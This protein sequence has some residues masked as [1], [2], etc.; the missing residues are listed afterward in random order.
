MDELTG[1]KT[2]AEFKRHQMI[3]RLWLI[4]CGSFVLVMFLSCVILFGRWS[5]A[6]DGQRLRWIG[7]VTI[8]SLM[9]QAVIAGSFA[10][11]G[12]VGRWRARWRDVSL[13]ADDDETSARQAYDGGAA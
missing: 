3:D 7:W 9:L 12:P 4:Y 11:G 8:G 1:P 6:L 10:L 2:P 5:P 13:G